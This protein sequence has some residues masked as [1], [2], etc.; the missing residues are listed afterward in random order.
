MRQIESLGQWWVWKYL[1]TKI[2]R[3]FT[4]FSPRRFQHQVMFHITAS[5]FTILLHDL[6]EKEAPALTSNKW[7][8]LGM[9][10]NTGGTYVTLYLYDIFAP[11]NKPTTWENYMTIFPH[12][13]PHQF[14]GLDNISRKEIQNQTDKLTWL[15]KM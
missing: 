11:N 4:C 13:R 12:H 1:E 14:S 3:H 15:I 10:I 9:C 7:W 5:R 6:V 8:L 2:I